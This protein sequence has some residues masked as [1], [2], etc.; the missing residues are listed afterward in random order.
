[1]TVPKVAVSVGPLGTPPVQF[2]GTDALPPA[3][4][5]HWPDPPWRARSVRPVLP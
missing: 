2:V 5:R 3:S 4:T 1:M